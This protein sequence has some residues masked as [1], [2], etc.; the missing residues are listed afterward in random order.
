[1]LLFVIVGFLLIKDFMRRKTNRLVATIIASTI[2]LLPAVSAHGTLRLFYVIPFG[3]MLIA[4]IVDDPLDLRLP[5]LLAAVLAIVGNGTSMAL[6]ARDVKSFHYYYFDLN[7]I[8]YYLI[9]QTSIILMVVSLFAILYPD[10][11]SAGRGFG[12]RSLPLDKAN[13]VRKTWRYRT[14]TW[15]CSSA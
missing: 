4:T 2:I 3:L 11:Q 12:R 9:G 15:H 5:L 10:V 7:P 1:M 6:F 14:T 8:T 13:A